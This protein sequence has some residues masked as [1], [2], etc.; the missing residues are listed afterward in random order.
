MSIP[1]ELLFQHPARDKLVPNCAVA[2]SST[3]GPISEAT[4]R[5]IVTKFK[6]PGGYLSALQSWQADHAILRSTIAA[7]TRALRA[8]P[9]G[10]TARERSLRPSPAR[11]WFRNRRA[12]GCRSFSHQSAD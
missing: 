12:Q 11:L 4:W 5:L 1:C 2:A 3:V 7:H 9:S 10:R 8:E 6:I